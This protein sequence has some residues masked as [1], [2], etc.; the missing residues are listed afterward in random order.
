VPTREHWDR[1]F[2]DARD[3]DVLATDY[4]VEGMHDHLVAGVADLVASGR[5]TLAQAVAL[6]SSGPAA[7]VPGVVRGDGVL[8]AGAPADVTVCREA[9]LRDVRDVFVDGVRVVADG[10]LTA[11]ARP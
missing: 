8:R 7:A 4:G 11:A 10:A 1:L 6:V 3:V 5:R 2:D 9:D